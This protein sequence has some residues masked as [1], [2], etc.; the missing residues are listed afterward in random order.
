MITLLFVSLLSVSAA[1]AAQSAVPAGA[2][3]APLADAAAD[4][5]LDAK[6]TAAGKDVGKLLELAA[7]CTAAGQDDDAKKVFAKVLEVD[8]ANEVA[9]KGLRHQ[10]YDGK[11]YGSFA[12]LSKFKREEA[13]AM[14]A[15]GLARFKDGWVPE[16][17]VPF[18]T[19]GWTKDSSGGWEN[20]AEAAA[21]VQVAEWQKAGYVFRADD[22]S[23]VAPDDADLIAKLLWKCGDE[24]V[25]TD[26]ANAYH[27]EIGAWWQLVGEH[28]TVWT[29][30]DWDGGNWARWYADK[31]WPDLV[32][33]FGVE[34]ASR[35]HFIVLNSI[36]QYNQASGGNP[37]SI[38]ESEG[39]SSVFGAYFADA[40]FDLGVK[41]PLYQG[42]GV[43]FWD[44]ND[45]GLKA[46]GPGWLRW[47]A[48][49][50]YVDAIDPS[51]S[52]IAATISGGAGNGAAP[53][54]AAFWGEKKI[55]R[56]LRYGAAS[57][58]ERFM[59]NPDAPEGSDPWGLRAFAFGE[60]KKGGGLGKLEDVFAFQIDPN[61]QD[62]AAHLYQQAGLLVS[63]IL[64][65]AAGDKAIGSAHDAFRSALQSGS[66]AEV[67]A[68]AEALQKALVTS[69]PE[70]R[71]FAGL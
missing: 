14:K 68:A 42:A 67:T 38:P 33:L 27:T 5:A 10:F 19:M 71:K 22:N 53:N 4:P 17:D 46:W 45:A 36:S 3:T 56:W 51:W 55:P 12:E 24:W 20:P 43:S 16:A 49:Q 31:T 2:A 59:T 29:T 44:R 6:I 48:A 1:P 7:A 41:P 69:E 25:E 34:P 70:I 11:W 15:K 39:W 26:V 47:A 58:A 8:A 52:A 21:A 61:K 65:G 9:H 40:Y 50:S 62:E 30:C 54:A 28:F 13:A 35:P 66:K 57:Y 37:P 64:D 60:L 18:L 32:R 23:W 63:F